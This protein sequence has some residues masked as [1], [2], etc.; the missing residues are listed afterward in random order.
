MRGKQGKFQH[1]PKWSSLQVSVGIITC[2]V[3]WFIQSL[4]QKHKCLRQKWV[5]YIW[6]HIHKRPKLQVWKDIFELENRSGLYLSADILYLQWQSRSPMGFLKLA[7]AEA[8]RGKS[9]GVT[10]IKAK[11]FS[12]WVFKHLVLRSSVWDLNLLKPSGT[13]WEKYESDATIPK[14]ER[15]NQGQN[16]SRLDC[17]K[18]SLCCGKRGTWHLRSSSQN[19]KN[20]HGATSENVIRRT[21][22]ERNRC[23]IQ[24]PLSEPTHCNDSAVYVNIAVLIR[25]FVS[26]LAN[27]TVRARFLFQQ[28][29]KLSLMQGQFW[30]FLNFPHK[31]NKQTS[32]CLIVALLI[33][34]WSASRKSLVNRPFMWMGC[35]LKS[36][37]CCCVQCVNSENEGVCG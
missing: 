37:C 2:A 28:M 4:S 32:A 29:E 26:D 15:E 3:C 13:G 1:R 31:K 27:D 33:R 35:K 10:F 17:W 11:C 34:C 9:V 16:E 22:Q 18:Q 8:G 25:A 24:T 21:N 14:G 20:F 5:N 12:D 6:T 36:C 30:Q 23:K 7:G 19:L